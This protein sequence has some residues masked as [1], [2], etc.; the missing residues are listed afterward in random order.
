M[1]PPANVRS[2]AHSLLLIQ[3]L[4]GL[5]DGATPLTL[6]LD[7]LEQPS[8]PV[9][10]EF[11]ARAKVRHRFRDLHGALS[12]L[13]GHPAPLHSSPGQRFCLSHLRR[14]VR[15]ATST[16]SS[17]QLDVTLLPCGGSW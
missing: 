15:R 5:R 6:V 17:E 1:A 7:S 13:M 14:C 9:V 8:R 11:I 3:R 12:T 2:R 16:F 10:D 4:F